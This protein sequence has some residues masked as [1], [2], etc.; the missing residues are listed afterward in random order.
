YRYGYERLNRR[1]LYRH[2][3]DAPIAE[4][5]GFGSAAGDELLPIITR[6]RRITIIEPGRDFWRD[7]IAGVPAEYHLPEPSGDLPCADA[8]IDLITCLGVLH[9]IPNVSHVIA[10]FARV[11][12][13]GGRVLLREP[14]VSMGDWRRKR[15]SLTRHERGIP[16]P[17]FRRMIAAAGLEVVRE[18][19]FG[20]GPLRV[21]WSRLFKRSYYES[22]TGLWLDHLLASM[23]RW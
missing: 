22:A 13:P 14:I 5:L 17:L 1:Y 23:F 2:L 8:S 4:V 12:R 16:L 7:H 9:H 10:E 11:L 21:V 20:F 6:V 19:V 18:H 15:G 3:G